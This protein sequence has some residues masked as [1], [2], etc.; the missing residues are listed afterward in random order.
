MTDSLCLWTAKVPTAS[1]HTAWGSTLEHLVHTDVQP[2]GAKLSDSPWQKEDH[3]HRHLIWPEAVTSHHRGQSHKPGFWGS[4]IFNSVARFLA[5]GGKQSQAALVTSYGSRDTRKKQ[6]W[7]QYSPSPCHVLWV[8]IP[9]VNRNVSEFAH[10]SLFLW[11]SMICVPVL[12]LQVCVFAQG[13]C[14]SILWQN[15]FFLDKSWPPG[16]ASPPAPLEPSSRTVI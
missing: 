14:M 9:C 16:L 5:V 3:R 15:A 1:T 4:W 8:C 11:A 2:W 10:G 7:G 13:M 12:T 6:L